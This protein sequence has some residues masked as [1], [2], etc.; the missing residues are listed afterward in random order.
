MTARAWLSNSVLR[1]GTEYVP[2]KQEQEG[3]GGYFLESHQTKRP[4]TTAG[5]QSLSQA[6]MTLTVFHKSVLI[7]DRKG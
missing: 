7:V 1:F 5:P 2:R 6:S 4:T 3:M